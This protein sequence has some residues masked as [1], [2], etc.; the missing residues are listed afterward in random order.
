MG[1]GGVNPIW[2]ISKRLS[3]FLGQVVS[4]MMIIV[5]TICYNRSVDEGWNWPGLIDSQRVSAPLILIIQH[6]RQLSYLL[7]N[8][9][10][11]FCLKD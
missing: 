6:T 11:N 8:T 10:I 9:M 3:N 5:K 1:G 2:K 4:Y 7:L